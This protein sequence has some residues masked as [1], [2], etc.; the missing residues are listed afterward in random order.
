MLK[1]NN[2]FFLPWSIWRDGSSQSVS[3]K[4]KFGSVVPNVRNVSFVL[5][6]FSV[7]VKSGKFAEAVDRGR[8]NVCMC[9]AV[10]GTARLII[11]TGI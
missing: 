6:S 2:D 10:R 1:I 8:P 4:F 11:R 9:G 3:P 7:A 5:C